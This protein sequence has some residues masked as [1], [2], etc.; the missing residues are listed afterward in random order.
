MNLLELQNRCAEIAK[1]KG[2][3]NDRMFLERSIFLEVGE[4]V[5]AV[6]SEESS[7]TVALEACDVMVFLFQYIREHGGDFNL[8]LAMSQKLME[9]QFF[10]KKTWNG[11]EIIRK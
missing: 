11:A 9:L 4:L 10:E 3:S 1:L 8:D 7:Q 6:E 2:F 5:K